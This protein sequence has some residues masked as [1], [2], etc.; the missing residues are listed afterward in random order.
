MHADRTTAHQGSG[1]RAGTRAH[2]LAHPVKTDCAVTRTARRP[3]RCNSK[4]ACPWAACWATEMIVP[5]TFMHT[6]DRMR[7]GRG[8]LRW[9]H[10]KWGRGS[11][12]HLTAAVMEWQGLAP[13]HTI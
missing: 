12:A 6:W 10:A 1:A 13:R 8:A 9:Q 11:M 5:L 3:C 4:K 7:R 2:D